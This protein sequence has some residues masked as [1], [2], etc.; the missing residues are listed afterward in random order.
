MYLDETTQFAPCAVIAA[1]S[2]SA[3]LSACNYSIAEIEHYIE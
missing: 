1:V 3:Y 2:I